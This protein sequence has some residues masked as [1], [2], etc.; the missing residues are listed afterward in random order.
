MKKK[1][2]K[3]WQIILIVV[4]ILVIAFVVSLV[5]ATK[6]YLAEYEAAR[7]A[8]PGNA[9]EYSP[10]KVEPLENSPLQ[11]KRILFLGSSVTFGVGEEGCSFVEYIGKR[12]GVDVTKEAVSGT[13]LV[14]EASIMGDNYIKRLEKVDTNQTFDAV[15]VQ[16]STN[17]ATTNKTL[18]EISSS[19]DRSDF[20]TKTVTGA[21]EYI[22][23]Y[24]RETW[25]CPVVFYTNSYFDN[26]AYAAMV[27]RLHELERKWDFTVVDLYSNEEFNSID[28]EKRDF[29][30]MDNIHPTKAGYLEWWTPFIEAALYDALT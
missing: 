17:D 8:L 23:A 18:G 21:I 15:V 30:M 28:Q 9:D 22:I 10:E 29:Y 3:V 2:I 25:N 19:E 26:E 4:L 6:N 20:D 12:N 11:G 14:T 24:C 1:K 27:E 7:A 16:L 5:S 13:T